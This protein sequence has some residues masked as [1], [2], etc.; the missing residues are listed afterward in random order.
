MCLI[1]REIDTLID[2]GVTT[3]IAVTL[4]NKKN[5][6][7][8]CYGYADDAKTVE[9]N[10][11]TIFDLASVTKLFLA[12]AYFKANEV[13]KIDFNKTLEFYCG[14]KFPN[15]SDISLDDLFHFNCCLTTDKRIVNCDYTSA[16]EQIH[17][18]KYGTN[19][20]QIYSDMPS[21]VLGIVFKDIVGMEFGDF[22]NSEFIDKCGLLNT[23]WGKRYKKTDNYINYDNEMIIRNNELISF[24]QKPLVVNDKKAEILSDKGRVLCGNAGLFSSAEDMMKIGQELISRN[25]LT[26]ETL[27]QIA[28]PINTDFVQRFGYLSYSKSPDRAVSEIYSKMSDKAFA[29]SGFTGTYFMVDPINNCF[30]FIGGNKLNN[31]ITYSDD[32]SIIVDCNKICFTN[33]TY[34]YTKDYV[35]MKDKL[36]DKCCDYLLKLS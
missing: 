15:I 13:Q 2:S 17:N 20:Q 19:N 31:R 24:P 35:Y 11:E 28:T 29:I 30:L 36:R 32:A 6:E 25:L 7:I 3:G 23:F 34:Y 14:N 18:I 1:K 16:K 12:L 27:M 8:L 9:I 4:G 10:K 5:S 33:R 21:L 22:L 26:N